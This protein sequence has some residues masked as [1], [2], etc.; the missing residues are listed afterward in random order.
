MKNPDCRIK[1]IRIGLSC[2]TIEP[3]IVYDKIDGIGTYTKNLYETLIINNQQV[4]PI[5]FP[6]TKKRMISAFPNGRILNFSYSVSTISSF[7]NPINLNRNLIKDIDILHVTDH[8]LP[9]IRHVPMIATICDSIMFKRSDWH[10]NTIRFGYIKKWLRKKTMFW[11][12]HFITISNAMVPELVED[13]GIK[14]EKIS[15]VHLGV[16]EHWFE[17]ISEENKTRVLKKFNLP[18]RF[19]LFTGTVQP[20]KNLSRIIQAY[21][22]LPNDIQNEF[23]LVIV[24]RP[25]LG[26]EESLLAIETL[27]KKRKGFWLN[28]VAIEELQALFQ[29]ATLYI[30][31]SLHEGFGLTILEAFASEVPTITSNITALPEVANGAAYLVDPYSISEITHA[32]NSLLTSSTMRTELIQKGSIRAK[33]FCWTTCMRETIKIYKKFI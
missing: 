14:P 20:K 4:I 26:S 21:L 31:P 19:I 17:K 24:G 30:H 18:D 22:Q 1:N 7:I 5:S 8:M 3:S 29:C 23:P 9:K 10:W 15:V 12:D 11:A 2:T 33:Q 25:G 6:N 16:A 28:Y 27:V 13:I 32:L